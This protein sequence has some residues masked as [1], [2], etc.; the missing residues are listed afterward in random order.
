MY[1]FDF[2][3]AIEGLDFL[4]A[5]HGAEIA[6]VFASAANPTADQTTVSNVVQDYW[7]RFARTG[8]PNGNAALAWPNFSASANKR[9]NIRPDPS[10]VDGFRAAECAFWRET[11]DAEFK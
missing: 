7:T 10:V 9:L 6:F 1:N 3:I 2:P 8:D 4:G 11:Y 5:T